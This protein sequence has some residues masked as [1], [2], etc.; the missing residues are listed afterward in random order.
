M[1]ST[2]DSSYMVLSSK[3]H[4]KKERKSKMLWKQREKIIAEWKSEY[5]RE[6]QTMKTFEEEN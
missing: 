2:S 6:L 5:K 3:K 4:K 1:S